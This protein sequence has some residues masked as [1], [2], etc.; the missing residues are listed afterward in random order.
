MQKQNLLPAAARNPHNIP[1]AEGRSSQLGSM[2]AIQYIAI[3]YNM[4]Y[5]T[6]FSDSYCA[7]GRLTYLKNY[8]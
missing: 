3:H 7:G 1:L 4:G 5:T 8:D 2:R 6:S